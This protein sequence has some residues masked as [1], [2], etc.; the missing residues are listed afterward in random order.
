MIGRVVFVA[1]GR[2][3]ADGLAVL[4]QDLRDRHLGPDFHAGFASSVGDGIR[5]RASTAA[6]ESPGAKRAVDLAHV[7]VQQN[8]G[9]SGRAH[10]EKG[11]DDS[12]GRHRGLEHVGLEPLVEKVDRA[13]GHELHLVVLVFAV[14]VFEAAAQ[15]QQLHQVFGIQRGGIGRHHGED[16]LHEAAHLQHRLAEFVVGLGVEL[17]V[18]RNLAPRHA[19]IVDA[20]QVVAVGHGREGAV[21]RQD[22]K[23]VPG[24]IEFANDLRPQQRHHVGA[25]GKLEAGENLLGDG[26]A[27]QHVPPLQNQ[28]FLP[29]S[30]QI[31]CVDQAIVAAANHDGVIFSGCVG[32]HSFLATR[33]RYRNESSAILNGAQR[34]CLYHRGRIVRTDSCA[35]VLAAGSRAPL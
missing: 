20:P 1:G 9:G 34:I 18:A 23:A 12:R 17:G 35:C 8:V 33:M 21:E 29:R 3:H 13:H 30:C 26:R 15:E 10:A 14:E 32:S 22:F 25:H 31:G 19:V 24:Q 6:G 2:G 5:N 28:D 11:A 7:V 16:R 27:A 4:D